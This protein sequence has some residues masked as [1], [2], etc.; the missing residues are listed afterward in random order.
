M[1]QTS[2]KLEF[3]E[4]APFWIMILMGVFFLVL[5][6]PMALFSGILWIYLFPVVG[7]ILVIFAW[8]DTITFDKNL[9]HLTIKQ[10]Y[11]LIART[12][13][14]KH[15]IQDI[16]GVEIQESH[17]SDSGNTYC[18]CLVVE[19][20]Q[21]RVPL[22]SVSTSSLRDK[23][24]RAEVIATFLN[25]RN[26]GLEGFPTENSSEL[27]WDTIQEEILHWE[28]AI[29]SDPNDPDTYM[30]LAL[31][32]INEDRGK[33]KEQAIVYIKQAEA[34]FRAQGYDEEAIQAGILSGALWWT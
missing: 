18:V 13:I 28:T 23:Q 2:D 4:M 1:K 10:Y 27:Q 26:Y 19:P 29:K 6:L 31:A 21:Q 32:L 12:K 30:K 5:G 9:G 14:T 11:P 25:I 8:I 3:V 33:N 22:T 16:L 20:G 15:L 34:M 24:E 17:D 7:L